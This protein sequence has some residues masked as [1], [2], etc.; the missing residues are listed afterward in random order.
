MEG[1]REIFK[2]K[3]MKKESVGPSHKSTIANCFSNCWSQQF[4]S[5]IN[6]VQLAPF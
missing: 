4:V 6:L 3:K 1:K 5:K 2:R